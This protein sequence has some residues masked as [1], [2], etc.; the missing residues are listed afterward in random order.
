MILEVA[1]L[2]VKAGMEAEFERSF[3]QA[4]KI[5]EAIRGYISHEL[6]HCIERESHHLLLVLSRIILRALEGL[7]NINNGVTCYITSTTRSQL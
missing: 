4:Q 5:I 6:Q 7:K 3:A 2:D 1:T